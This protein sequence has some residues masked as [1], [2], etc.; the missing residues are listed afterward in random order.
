MPGKS[1][2]PDQ[3]AQAV[4]LRASGY[5]V[6]AISERLGVSVSTLNRIFHRHRTTK[7]LAKDELIA[8]A[9]KDLIEAVTSNERIKEEA[10]RLVA[11]DLAHCR[12]LR[13]KV[14]AAYELLNPTTLEEAGIAM[15]AAA[16]A[17]T[18][19]KVT[20]DTVRHAL[21]SDKALDA[22]EAV[23]LPTLTIVEISAEEALRMRETAS[24]ELGE[25]SATPPATTAA[26]SVVELPDE[27]ERVSEGGDDVD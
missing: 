24:D 25:P 22:Q 3:T 9:R 21:R 4:A 14:A 23:D 1:L 13:A 5:T 12:L 6:T 16:A 27:N 11:D 20:S 19:I 26:G 2:S 8:A 15:R 10:A 18:T 17:A 7:G